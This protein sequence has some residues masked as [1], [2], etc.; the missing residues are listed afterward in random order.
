MSLP[1][2]EGEPGSG[3][4]RIDFRAVSVRHAE[5]AFAVLRLQKSHSRSINLAHHADPTHVKSVKRW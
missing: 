3:E 1:K 2:S 5:M 4:R